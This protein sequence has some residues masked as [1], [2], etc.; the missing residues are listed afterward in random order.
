DQREGASTSPRNDV[1]CAVRQARGC[2]ASCTCCDHEVLHVA[3]EEM[4]C[5][6]D[7][8]TRAGDERGLLHERGI[9]SRSAF[10]PYR[11]RHPTRVAVAKILEP[12]GGVVGALPRV[13]RA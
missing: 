6:S 5:E 7:V 9:T 10:D 1:R 2:E 11:V 4:V 13:L 8:G 3:I 12:L